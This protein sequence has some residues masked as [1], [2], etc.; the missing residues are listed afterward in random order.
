MEQMQPAN[1]PRSAALYERALKSLPG[2]NSRSTI[3]REPHPI[4]ATSGAGCR[5]TDVDGVARI[6]LVNNMSALVHGH[7]HPAIV[8]AIKEQAGKLISVGAPTES[9]ITLAEQLCARVESVERVNFCNSGSEAVHYAVRAARGFT[10]RSLIAKAEGAYHGNAD[11]VSV[12]VFPAPNKSGPMQA[13]TSVAASGG[14]APS[15]LGDTLVLPF[16]DIDNSRRLIAENASRLACVIIDPAPPR[17]GFIEASD[18]YLAMLRAETAKRGIVLVFDEVFSFRQSYRGAQGRR[19]VHADLTCFGKLIGGGM[20]IG[21]TG[22][23]ADIM[24][25]FD[26]RGGAKVEHGGTFN[27]NPVTMAAGAAALDLLTPEAIAHLDALGEYMRNGL[28]AVF[29]ESR[30]PAFV[31]GVGSL[32][33]FAVGVETPLGNVRDIMTAMTA[34]TRY[35]APAMALTMAFSQRLFQRG[36]MHASPSLFILSTAMTKADIDEVLDMAREAATGIAR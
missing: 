14:I 29:E 23:K 18:A 35:G 25:V 8:A 1:L 27:A 31:Q 7:S 16:N 4:Y 21:A 20:P 32:L 5:F 24:A 28:R 22:G 2:G 12:S 3:F 9:E 6:D 36:A 17:M 30:V 13:P 34:P 10:G 15:T 33:S 19:D 11:S 26:P